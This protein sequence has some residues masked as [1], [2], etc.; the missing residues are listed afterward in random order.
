[1][2]AI[3]N[4]C[5]PTFGRRRAP[6][7]LPL[8]LAASVLGGCQSTKEPLP[9]GA[10]AP[11]P[12]VENVEAKLVPAGGSAVNGTAVL[13]Q[14]G[15]GVD[16][17][18]WLGSAGPGEYRVAIHETGNCSSRN[19]FS[20]GAPWAPPGVTV[21]V[22]LLSKNDD[23]RTLTARLPGY[24]VEGPQG[25]MGRAVIVHSGSRSSLDAQPGVANDRIACG[26]IGTPDPLFPRLGF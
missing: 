22:V 8:L 4:S 2:I 5:H 26:V 13:H 1:V 6:R 25:V 23:T 18:L 16:L 21:A 9:P 11:P 24:R 3:A 10:P 15:S 12:R 7:A 19:A 14:A 17:S 20:A